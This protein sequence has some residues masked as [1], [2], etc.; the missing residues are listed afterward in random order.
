MSS[1]SY[2]LENVKWLHKDTHLNSRG[3]VVKSGDTLS[4]FVRNPKKCLSSFIF[5][6]DLFADF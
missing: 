3:A 5:L 4:V 6:L 2:L 1:F